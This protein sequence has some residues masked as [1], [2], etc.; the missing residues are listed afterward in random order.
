MAIELI[1]RARADALQYQPSTPRGRIIEGFFSFGRDDG[2]F[3]NPSL[4]ADCAFFDFSI[5]FYMK[6]W[7]SQKQHPGIFEEFFPQI[8]G[9]L[10]EP[11][12]VLTLFIYDW[13]P[14]YFDP[15]QHVEIQ[16]QP[17]RLPHV[18]LPNNNVPAPGSSVAPDYLVFEWPLDSLNYILEEH[19]L[20]CGPFVQT[21]GYVGKESL[22]DLV[23]RLYSQPD[24]EDRIRGL[25]F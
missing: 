12:S 23:T 18:F 19:W 25:L 5:S 15:R 24:T 17:R 8:L 3:S 11:G 1:V 10:V 20:H 7:P 2:V 13:G 16:L 21:E 4:L 14:G 22:L 9:R 6:G